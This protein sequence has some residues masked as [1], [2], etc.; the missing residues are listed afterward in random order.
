MKYGP[1]KVHVEYGPPPQ[2]QPQPQLQSHSHSFQQSSIGGHH[3]HHQVHHGHED[4][5][6]FE[7]LKQTFGFGSSQPN[8]PSHHQPHAS[9]G[10]PPQA[11]VNHFLPPKP[12]SK[13]GPPTKPFFTASKPP[14]A[15]GECLSSVH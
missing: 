14:T 9:Y 5:S 2:A 12:H 1:P 3:H 6:F 10:P 7:Q 4:L 13:Y 15:Y 11:P 8:Y